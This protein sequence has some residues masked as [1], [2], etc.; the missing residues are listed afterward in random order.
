M[1]VHAAKILLA[2]E[3]RAVLVELEAGRQDLGKEEAVGR[4]RELAYV[5]DE[6]ARP[7]SGRRT[8]TVGL[9]EC[10]AETEQPRVHVDHGEPPRLLGLGGLHRGQ[11]EQRHQQGQ[12]HEKGVV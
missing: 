1:L 7:K 2:E 9:Q 11:E 10:R 3:A 6:Q 8:L 4:E 5:E 12:G